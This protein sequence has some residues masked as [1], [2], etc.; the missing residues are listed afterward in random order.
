MEAVDYLCHPRGEHTGA[1]GWV[2]FPRRL[3][4]KWNKTQTWLKIQGYCNPAVVY[5]LS[6]LLSQNL[7]PENSPTS[8]IFNTCA[9]LCTRLSV[10]FPNQLLKLNDFTCRNYRQTSSRET[11]TLSGHT[12]LFFRGMLEIDKLILLGKYF[13][14]RYNHSETHRNVFRMHFLFDSK[15]WP[16]K[17]LLWTDMFRILERGQPSQP[18]AFLVT[19]YPHVAQQMFKIQVN[20]ISQSENKMIK[21]LQMFKVK[22]RV[23]CLHFFKSGQAGSKCFWNIPSTA[24]GLCSWV[25]GE[26]FL[27]TTGYW[28][29]E[30]L[31]LG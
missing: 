2:P 30:A 12:H 21:F 16:Q 7:Q 1:Q 27:S 23:R 14:V 28:P 10:S 18:P 9:Q 6:C 3:P 26:N 29:Q 5:F 15:K 22:F 20:L 13:A 25:L 31:L 24:R 8:F 17:H 19:G 11:K 4:E